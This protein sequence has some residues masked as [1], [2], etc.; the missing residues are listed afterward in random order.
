MLQWASVSYGIFMCLESVTM[1]SWSADQLRKMQA[2]GNGKLNAFLQQYGIDK[3][4]DINE[5]YNTKA[6]EPLD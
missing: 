3:Y 5:K 1:D 2:G 6:A 4:T